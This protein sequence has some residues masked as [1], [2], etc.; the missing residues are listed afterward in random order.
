MTSAARLLRAS[1]LLFLSLWFLAGVFAVTGDPFWNAGIGDWMDPYFIN[2]LLE[3]WNH[4]LRTLSDPAS[5]PM[6]FPAA[7]TLGYSHGL[8]LFAPFYVLVRL[9][10]HHPFQAYSAAL[11][12]VA[13]TGV[14]CLYLF[15]RRWFAL[16]FV[17]SLLLTL[18]FLTSLNVT[19]GFI[20]IWS[21]RA[22]VFLIPPILLLLV[23]AKRRPPGRLRTAGL[24]SA[25]LFSLLMFTQDFYTA[26][27]GLCFV[28]AAFLAPAITA[29]GR[30][31]ALQA[32]WARSSRTGRAALLIAAALLSWAFFVAASGGFKARIFGVRIASH[33]WTRPAAFAIILVSFS[34]WAARKSE[35]TLP[36]VRPDSWTVPFG[37][38]A[39][40]GLAIFL[41][42]YAGPYREH[43]TFP[44]QHLTNSLVAVDLSAAGLMRPILENHA[45]YESLRT[46][47]FIILIALLVWVPIFKVDR[48]T[49]LFCLWAL[50]VS[51]IV[52]LIPLSFNG[53]SIWKAFF[54]PL[55]GFSAIRDPKRIAYLFELAAVIGA[56]ALMSSV[57]AR[58][59]LRMVLAL[60]LLALLITER[61]GTVFD[62]Q[63]P[64]ATFGQWVSAPISV[65]PACRSFYVSPADARYNQRSNDRWTLYSIDAMFIALHTSIPT[66][67]GYS[68]WFP[69]G[70]AFQNPED[71]G[72][73]DAVRRWVT[74]NHLTGVCELDLTNRIMAPAFRDEG[75]KTGTFEP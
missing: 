41:W 67:N 46:F 16:S 19:N 68:A 65:D 71:T 23:S 43:P 66:L 35:W 39:I 47:K 20:G 45:G 55:P 69:R 60:A 50:L 34:V 62:Y 24:F 4:S 49:K 3:H 52:L 73:R 12:L 56:G 40:A 31:D 26:L 10:L 7:R 9:F 6:Y 29:P 18:F 64:N 33:D 53:F 59:P 5:P 30:G 70:W 48:R 27:F 15:L 51:L 37:A 75:S 32:L 63:R 13:E 28:L 25:G 57:P 14:V 11:F 54:A 21:Q 44:V 61:N 22:S 17:E 2:Y 36:R 72:Y 8:V 1:V 42:L 58:S 38:G 74:M